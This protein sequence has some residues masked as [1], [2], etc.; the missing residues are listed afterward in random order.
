M[1]NSVTSVRWNIV[2]LLTGFSFVSYVQRMNISIASKFM[3]PAFSLSQVQ[4][5]QVFSS[6][7][8]GYALLQIPAGRLGD[9]YGP[10][11]VL[12]AAAFTWGLTTLLTGLLPGLIIS[13]AWG[14]LAT[15]LVLRF[16]LGVGEAATYPVAARAIGNWIPSSERAL[17][18]AIVV[19]GLSL[20][21]AATPPLISWLMVSVGWRTSFYITAALA[22][23]LAFV[24]MSYASDNPR[25]H[26]SVGEAELSRIT[27]GQPNLSLLG[28]KTAPWGK[29]LRDRDLM[30][31]SLSYF[32]DGYVLF[33]FVFWLY[34]YLLEV[35]GFSIL[36]GGIFASLPFIVSSIL[37]PAGG[38]L[39]DALSAKIGRRVARRTITI[40]GFTLSA[41][42][43]FYG[44]RVHNPYAATTGLA[45]SVGFVQFTEGA[46]WSTAIDISGP[47]AGVATGIMNMLG[48][49][50][51]LASTALV[52]IIVEYFGWQ[53]ALRLASCLA[54]LGGLTWLVI[55]PDRA[56]ESASSSPG[57][58]SL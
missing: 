14:V 58:V 15:L 23:A 37:T 8:L 45:L 26:S 16:L 39:C 25:Q 49:L 10:R 53:A 47:H 9:R 42:F 17:A 4:M 44:A 43:L 11:I 56:I 27:Y 46:F 57:A 21:S 50:G 28:S 30:L 35:R 20:G 18:N 3:M 52:P 31:L 33:F 41:I 19:A 2:A 24:W 13:G 51:G 40:S 54:F 22:F 36:S 12:T 48:N 7:M 32:F 34:T 55:R 1:T 29:L 5:G 38:A 6:F